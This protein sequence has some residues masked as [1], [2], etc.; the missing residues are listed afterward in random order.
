MTQYAS[1]SNKRPTFKKKGHRPANLDLQARKLLAKY[2]VQIP[3]EEAEEEKCRPFHK[4]PRNSF[5]P[6]FREDLF[7]DAEEVVNPGRTAKQY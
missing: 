5:P 3:N 6:L 4:G 2:V 7:V 1:I